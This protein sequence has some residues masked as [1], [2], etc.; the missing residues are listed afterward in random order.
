MAGAMIRVSGHDCQG[1]IELLGHKRPHDLVRHS[2]RPERDDEVGALAQLRI[3]PVGPADDAGDTGVSLVAPLS[4]SLGEGFARGTFSALVE[5]DQNGRTRSLEQGRG[6]FGPPVVVPARPALRQ[7]DDIE[8]GQTQGPA[9]A[10]DSLLIA[11]DQLPLGAALETAHGQQAQSH[12]KS[13]G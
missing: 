9:H 12:D 8:A 1:P 3:E 4:D 7:F 2:E 5:H 13:L 10:V 11:L 6:L